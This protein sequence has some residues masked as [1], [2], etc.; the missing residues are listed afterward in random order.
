MRKNIFAYAEIFFSCAQKF[1]F[2]RTAVNF[3]SKEA[4]FLPKRRDFLFGRKGLF[5]RTAGNFLSEENLF[6]CGRQNIF[7]YKELSL[8]S[9]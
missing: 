3:R 6:S 1:F 5:L 7:E 2:F 9:K 8:P 4:F